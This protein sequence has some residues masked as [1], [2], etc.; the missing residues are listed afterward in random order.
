VA[1]TIKDPE[2]DGHQQKGATKREVLNAYD[3]KVHDR[4]N[5]ESEFAKD[6]L[7]GTSATDPK[8]GRLTVV[9]LNTRDT[10]DYKVHPSIFNFDTFSLILT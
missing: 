7:V 5:E 1:T 2:R 4:A 9:L 10:V 6:V 8:T 3:G